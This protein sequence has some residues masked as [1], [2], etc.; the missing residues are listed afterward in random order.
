MGVDAAATQIVYFPGSSVGVTPNIMIFRQLLKKILCWESSLSNSF[1]PITMLS[2]LHKRYSLFSTLLKY[3][4]N[5]YMCLL[6]SLKQDLIV[7]ILEISKEGIT[8]SKIIETLSCVSESQ[9]NRTLAYIVDNRLLIFTGTNMQYI[10]T[11]RGYMYLKE[12]YKQ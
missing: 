3:F 5:D 1:W 2:A 11:H 8:K 6:V 10:T 9:I 7:K 12:R 4:S